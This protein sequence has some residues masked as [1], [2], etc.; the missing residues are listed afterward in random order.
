MRW[1]VKYLQ[2]V[3]FLIVSSVWTQRRTVPEHFPT[4][5]LNGTVQFRECFTVDLRCD[6]GSKIYKFHQKYIILLPGHGSSDF[7]L[8]LCLPDFFLLRKTEIIFRFSTV[9][10][11]PPLRIWNRNRLILDYSNL[12]NTEEMILNII[13]TLR[14]HRLQ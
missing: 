5:V 9:L 7:A 13:G 10:R 6:D 4:S 1:V 14:A 8:R 11:N 3:F 2:S 12:K